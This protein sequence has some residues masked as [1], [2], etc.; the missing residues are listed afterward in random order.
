MTLN[1]QS[2]ILV[3]GG[4][5]FLG[6]HVVKQALEK[7]YNVRVTART[8]DSAQ[9]IV[10][11]HP[12]H[13]ER[14]SYAVVPDL[15]QAESYRD[16]LNAG[17]TGV[18]HLASP[19]IFNPKDNVRDLLSPA[20]EGSTAMLEAVARW[21]PS[22]SRVVATSSYAAV[23]DVSLNPRAGYTYTEADWN[24]ATYGRAAASPDGPY[25]YRAS[26]ALAERAM[27]D[28]VEENGR[29]SADAAAGRNCRFTL[30][31]ICPPWI[32]GPYVRD[33]EASDRLTESVRLFAALVDAPDI[34]PF[35]FGGYAD[36]R[37][38]AAAHLLALEAAP[39]DARVDG[40]RFI[41]GQKFRYQTAVDLARE[42]LPELRD[43]LPVGTPGYVEPGFVMDGSR[44]VEDLGLQYMTLRETVADMLR[45]L[46]RS[47][48]IKPAT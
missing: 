29:R 26:K 28:W 41:V 13:K 25:V 42:A 14:L 17:V 34:P 45:Q 24:L 9:R 16:A 15:T 33:P 47:G 6:G 7:G 27:F 1:N 39:D 43:R 21:G 38:V 32:Y 8:E 23:L 48:H 19:F 2:T 44:A 4:S 46:L 10:A 35:D 18:L 37:E 11:A 3:T 30:T 40:R 22:V 5:G 20:I 36:V 12:E 31:T